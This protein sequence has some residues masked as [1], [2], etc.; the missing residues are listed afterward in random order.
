MSIVKICK[1]HGELTIEQVIHSK[2]TKEASLRC[3]ECRRTKQILKK[4]GICNEVYEKMKIEQNGLCAICS[5]LP[6]MIG[7]SGELV[8]LAVD[9]CHKCTKHFRQLLCS[10][11]NTGLGYAKDNIQLLQNAINYLNSHQHMI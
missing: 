7:R 11:C 1:V 3:K 9:H 5:K 2:S 4:R 10:A 8:P 6:T